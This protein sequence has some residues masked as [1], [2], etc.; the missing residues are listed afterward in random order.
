VKKTAEK[1]AED[2]LRKERLINQRLLRMQEAY[3]IAATQYANSKLGN[4]PS[5]DI[6]LRSKLLRGG[7]VGVTGAMGGV[8]ADILKIHT[9]IGQR[10]PWIASG[11]VLG[12]LPGSLVGR[13]LAAKQKQGL[14]DAQDAYYRKFRRL[15][16]KFLQVNKFGQEFPLPD[17]GP[18]KA[19]TPLEKKQLGVTIDESV[20]AS[21]G[22][23]GAAVT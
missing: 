1:I 21:T 12:A 10:L 17:L 5:T 13:S 15:K 20:P 2:I 8:L 16:N 6:P 11:T 19:R 14:L 3:D 22:E 18:P 9:P 23:L 7:L 4:P